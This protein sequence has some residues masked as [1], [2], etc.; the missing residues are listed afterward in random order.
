MSEVRYGAKETR[1]IQFCADGEEH[2]VRRVNTHFQVLAP[3]TGLIEVSE[4]N[5]EAIYEGGSS[6]VNCNV[7]PRH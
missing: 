5:M 6:M 4:D 2:T 7:V 3:V 1:L